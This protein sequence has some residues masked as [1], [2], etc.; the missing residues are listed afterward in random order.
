M[1]AGERHMLLRHLSLLDDGERGLLANAR[2][3]SEGI[4]VP[5]LDG[6]AFIDPRRSEVDIVQAVGRAIRKSGDKKVGTI[7]LPVFIDVD[8]DAETALNDSMFKPVWDVI[9]ALRAHDEQ[10]GEQFDSLRREL[11]RK[12]GKPKLPDK[13]HV[14]IP[15]KVDPSFASAFNVRL[16]EK[17]T[18]PWEFWLGLMDE[19][20]AEY[21]HARVPHEY[22]TKHGHQLGYWVQNQRSFRRHGMLSADRISDLESLHPTWSW[23]PFDAGWERGF[24]QLRE[25]V[26]QR[27]DARVPQNYKTVDGFALGSWAS[28]QRNDYRRGKLETSRQYRIEALHPTWTWDLRAARW[29]EGFEHLRAF[30]EQH[31]HARVPGRYL[32]AS[33]FSLGSWVN[34]LR[35]SRRKGTLDEEYEARLE[36]LHPTW[37]WKVI[38]DRWEEGFRHL[39]AFVEQT[40]H[41]S[42]PQTYKTPDRFLLGTWVNSQR[43]AFR[44]CRLDAGYQIRIENLHPTWSWAPHTDKWEEGFQHLCEFVAKHGHARVPNEYRTADGFLLRSWV[45]EQRSVYRRGKLSDDRKAR[46][47]NLDPS[48]TWDAREV[49]WEEGFDYLLGYVEQ[50]GHA[51]VPAAYR[52][53]DGYPLGGW[54]NR[55]RTFHRTRTHAERQA[56]LEAVPGWVWKAG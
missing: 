56:R 3:L 20:I 22:K 34:N 30:I 14:D 33:G 32:T 50:F 37:S 48:W 23:E 42:V 8:T 41:A 15:T 10:L 35:T 17:T 55:Q 9:L 7:V 1:T 18:A 21:G 51:R 27:G 28:K 12:R 36:N 4:D 44:Q 53:S 19:F 49:R 24:D 6:V 52:T 26:E 31:G 25:Y 39:C 16:V 38:G 43:D 2:C 5:A 54:V 47:E 29:N 40:G 13:I 46:L 45:K 11:G